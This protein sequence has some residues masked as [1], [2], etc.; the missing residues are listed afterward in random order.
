MFPAAEEE[1]LWNYHYVGL[2]QQAKTC[3]RGVLLHSGLRVL[4]Q[5]HR[6]T[7]TQGTGANYWHWY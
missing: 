4:R 1:P 3:Q 6:A 2:P 5:T 7:Q